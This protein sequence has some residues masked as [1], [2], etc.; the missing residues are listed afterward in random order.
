MHE[1][2]VIVF[3]V[4]FSCVCVLTIWQF[5]RDAGILKIYTYVR[6]INNRL[7]LKPFSCTVMTI[8]ITHDYCFQ[9]L[10]SVLFDKWTHL[11]IT[12]TIAIEA[13]FQTKYN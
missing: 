6:K 8:C 9:T 4:L 5:K 12:D 2:I 13:V 10:R 3:F 1:D 11:N 7:F